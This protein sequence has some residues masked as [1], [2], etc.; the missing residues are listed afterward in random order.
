[1]NKIF[2]STISLVWV[3]PVYLSLALF[4]LFHIQKGGFGTNEGKGRRWKGNEV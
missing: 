3:C 1:M 2:P 4:F